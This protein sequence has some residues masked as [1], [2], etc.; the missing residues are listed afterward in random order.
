[1]LDF[2]WAYP[3]LTC[4]TA[5]LALLVLMSVLAPV[6]APYDPLQ[7]NPNATL[8]PPSG[9]HWLGTD[10][11]GRDVWSRVLY[12]GKD[13]LYIAVLSGVSAT[14]IGVILGLI[15]GQRPG[16]VDTVIMRAMESV[17]AFPSLI[18]ALAISFALGSSFTSILI[19]VT[20]SSIPRTAMLV[21]GEV[22]AL[23][24]RKFVDS[25]RVSGA[26]STR[27]MMRHELPNM[28]EIITVQVAL[29]TGQAI[30]ISA[31]LAFLGLGLPPP[32]PNWGGLLKDGYVFLANAPLQ[33]L[34][35]G[36]LIFL[37]LLAF[38]L[39]GD[40]LRDYFDPRTLSRQRIR[41]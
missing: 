11:L 21:R 31:S 17:L 20:V 24:N 4:G 13:T 34:A 28:T 41:R 9:E 10:L 8:L 14:V 7:N 33:C 26:S 1:M 23:A 36:A 37:A 12:G 3:R 5:L 6:L 38:N 39:I 25:A 16:A 30:F 19:A 27:I 40:G 2:V 22:R 15:A 18:L 29:D 32:A 35:P